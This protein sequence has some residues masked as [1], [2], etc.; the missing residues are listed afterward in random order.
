MSSAASVDRYIPLAEWLPLYRGLLFVAGPCSVES[1][2][3]L[4]STAR[5]L[6]ETGVVSVLRAGVWKPR[7]R[8]G[9]FEGKGV[10]ALP[11][12]S[13]IREETGLP[14]A[15]EAA[16]PDHAE[17]CLKHGVDMI[18]LGARTTVNPFMVQEIANAIRGTGMPVM[19]KNPVCPDLRLWIGAIERVLMAGSNKI[20][21]IHRGFQ[22]HQKTVYR[23]IPIWEIP[24]ALQVQMPG[25]P[26]ICDPSHIAGDKRWIYEVARQAMTLRMDGLM[27]E[28]HF[29]PAEALTDPH[30]QI[31]PARL[32]D[33]LEKLLNKKVTEPGM[34]HDLDS[35]RREIDEYDQRL[36]ELLAYRLSLSRQAGKIKRQ[37]GVEILQPERQKDLFSDRQQRASALGLAPDF[38]ER[39]LTVLHEQSVVIQSQDK[40]GGGR[41]LQHNP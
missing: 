28:A 15:V 27:T 3:Q 33:I 29:R 25:L 22:T 8:P 17:L 20:I 13:A 31:T 10:E 7:S 4:D 6:A 37:H 23:N 9:R 21:A 11:W 32:K 18:W 36:L 40:E 26:L 14:V 16:R 1:R 30:Q 39:V 35:L 24:L 38:V 12:L 5:Q 34:A 41:Q 19:I 2:E